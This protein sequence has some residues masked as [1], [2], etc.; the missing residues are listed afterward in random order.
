ML[1]CEYCECYIPDEND[2]CPHCGAPV[3]PPVKKASEV[4]MEKVKTGLVADEK[5]RKAPAT[6]L[7]KVASV[8][9][10][11]CGALMLICCFGC[12]SSCNDG[13]TLFGISTAMMGVF[14]LLRASGKIP[15]KSVPRKI[16]FWL[17]FFF[18]VAS[19]PNV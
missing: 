3:K 15:L 6:P 4:A 11:C 19:A 16:L 17:L 10:W 1:K 5:A 7:G 9:W 18:V 2:N 12:L 14:C 8:I 13:D